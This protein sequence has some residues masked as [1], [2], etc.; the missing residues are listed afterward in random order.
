MNTSP[1]PAGGTFIEVN[2]RI[3]VEHPV[4]EMVTSIDIVREQ[5]QVAAG[6][7]LQ[8]TQGSVT[9]QGAALECR[10]NCEDPERGF[11]P[12]PGTLTTFLP[13]GGP[14]TRVDT[15]AFPGCTVTPS[16]DSLLAKVV[17]WGPDRATAV[18]RMDRALSEFQ[19]AGRAMCTTIPL[20]RRV[21]GDERFIKVTHT[22]SLLQQMSIPGA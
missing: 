19:V 11:A 10:V 3:Q 1:A 2:C 22:T 13:P 15:A 4:T 21:L 12:T 14:F 17:T 18:S 9:R 8:L 20:L 6:L 5:I 16:Y 7:P